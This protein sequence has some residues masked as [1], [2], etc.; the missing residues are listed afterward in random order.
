MSKHT[1][2]KDLSND[3]YYLTAFKDVIECVKKKNVDGLHSALHDALGGS[4]KANPLLSNLAKHLF[5]LYAELGGDNAKELGISFRAER[6]K[7]LSQYSKTL[8]DRQHIDDWV[9]Q[10][11]K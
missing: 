9:Q 7:I 6:D 2:N 10:Q 11:E 4:G 8:G 1:I 5:P 3:L